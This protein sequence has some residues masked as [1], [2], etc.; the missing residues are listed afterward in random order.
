ML[1]ANCGI[2]S[3]NTAATMD[4]TLTVGMLMIAS[5]SGSD[6]YSY[7]DFL[8]SENSDTANRPRLLITYRD[9]FGLE[10]YWTYISQSAGSAGTGSIN[11]S[12][13]KVMDISECAVSPEGKAE[14]SIANSVIF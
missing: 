11:L 4:A 2:S 3:T 5:M 6:E 13:G 1:T 10:D 9:Q 7:F 8:S 14:Y 12:N